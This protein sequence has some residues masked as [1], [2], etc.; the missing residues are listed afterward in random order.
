MYEAICLKSGNKMGIT[1]A[2]GEIKVITNTLHEDI[3]QMNLYNRFDHLSIY[4]K[5]DSLN[6]VG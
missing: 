5:S 6:P 4:N 1:I 3:E 2:V